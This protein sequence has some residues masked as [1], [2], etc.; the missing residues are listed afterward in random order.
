MPWCSIISIIGLIW[1]IIS[2]SV[3]S[4]THLKLHSL[5][6][7]KMQFFQKA[8]LLWWE[9]NCWRHWW[10]WKYWNAT[11]HVTRSP[12]EAIL[13]TVCYGGRIATVFKTIVRYSKAILQAVEHPP[14]F[15]WA[16]IHCYSFALDLITYHMRVGA[17]SLAFF[18]SVGDGA[19]VGWACSSMWARSD[20]YQ[21]T[22]Y[23]TCV[24]NQS[25]TYAWWQ[26]YHH[27]PSLTLSLGPVGFT[28]HLFLWLYINLWVLLPLATS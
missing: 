28:R 9:D 20:T 16:Q 3:H 27:C 14:C 25:N 23:S 4:L 1:L 11:L 24:R 17:A 7:L 13:H 10:S 15:G 12:V 2:R 5:L 22:K 18:P 6:S 21:A 8:R 26:I 19:H